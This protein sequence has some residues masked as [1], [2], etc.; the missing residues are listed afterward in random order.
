MER[1]VLFT[2]DG[3][4]VPKGRPRVTRH[5]TYTPKSTQIFEAAV[6]TAW[7]KTGEKP[8]E[9]GEALDVMVNAYFP[10]PSGTPKRERDGLHLTPYLK[11]G[12]IDNIIKAVLDALNGYAYK[13][14]SAV[15]SV[16]GRK[17]YTDG[18]PLTVV[19]ISSVEVDHEL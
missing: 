5:G 2:V 17:F 18:E 9:D 12:D 11:R 3:R 19:T 13:D 1:V 8:F 4:P 7:L 10:I 14:D 15:F 6:R 16:C